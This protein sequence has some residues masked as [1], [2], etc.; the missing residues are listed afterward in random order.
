[1]RTRLDPPFPEQPPG[2]LARDPQDLV[3][4]DIKEE[5]TTSDRPTTALFAEPNAVK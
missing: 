5:F 4:V 1:M 2:Q 3:F